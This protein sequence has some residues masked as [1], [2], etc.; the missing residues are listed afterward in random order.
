MQHILIYVGT[1]FRHN[2]P[3]FSYTKRHIQNRLNTI[4]QVYFFDE[5]DKALF[6]LL[7]AL[8]SQPVTLLILTSKNSFSVVGKLLC[9]L[10]EDSQ[11]INEGMLLPSKTEKQERNSYLLHYDQ[12]YIN[13]L[14][15]EP[16]QALPEL[17][18][19]AQIHYEVLHLFDE[20]DDVA[21][22]LD[23]IA[24]SYDVALKS[25]L[26]VKGWTIVELS[27]SRYGE[28]KSFIASAKSLLGD[29]II[30]ASNIITHVIASLE[31]AGKKVTCAES[32]TGGFLASLFTRES[33][34]S[35]VFEGSIVSYANEI[36]TSWLG[37]D[38]QTLI[39]YGA[40]SFET[41]LAMSAGAKEV[42]KADFAIAI[43][44]I[45]G[46]TGA[47]EGKP[48]GTVFV[49]ICSSAFHH[50]WEL[51]LHG[52]RNYI[53]MQSAFHGIKELILSDKAL[54]FS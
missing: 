19:E 27:S 42:A 41:A 26:F 5:N 14:L 22:L 44:G 9:T 10:T 49:S 34:A 18:I 37:V 40:V 47:V 33:G 17:L 3:L 6:L 51:H 53:Q 43:S 39:D 46:P 12:T 4:H 28:L 29:R 52:D 25:H 2:E 24:E 8:V 38:E 23:P 11:V 1:Q 45:A 20:G 32:C 50:A 7:E 31:K 21:I 16:L 30:A 35:S 36:K 48:V 54:F 13:T 15:V